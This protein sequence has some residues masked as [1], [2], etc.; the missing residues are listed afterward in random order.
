VPRRLRHAGPA[1]QL[2]SRPLGAHKSGGVLLLFLLSMLI[3]TRS[4]GVR[5]L[6]G[7]AG[8]VAAIYRVVTLNHPFGPPA[9]T[10]G[11]PIQNLFINLTNLVLE[12]ALYFLAA[13]LV[14]RVC[15]WVIDGFILDRR[16]R[17]VID[18]PVQPNDLNGSQNG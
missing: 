6:S 14:V 17:G 11:Q 16:T 2:T 10:P 18:A 1:A 3:S 15:A 13:W 9:Q 12:C 8:T 5:R 4:V 7:T